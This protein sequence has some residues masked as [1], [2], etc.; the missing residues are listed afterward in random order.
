MLMNDMG[1]NS[2]A[3]VWDR[4]WNRMA[5]L[6]GGIGGLLAFAG[7]AALVS[8]GS[9]TGARLAGLAPIVVGGLAILCAVRA[10]RTRSR[11]V[12]TLAFVCALGG[13]ALTGILQGLT[14]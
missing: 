7:I 2:R 6:A 5:M 12:M 8:P 3:Q 14:A 10:H 9:S 4:I 11:K 13:G 1:D